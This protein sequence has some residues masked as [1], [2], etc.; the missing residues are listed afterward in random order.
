MRNG[1]WGGRRPSDRDS[2]PIM[3]ASSIDRGLENPLSV[4]KLAPNNQ[5]KLIWIK[6]DAVRRVIARCRHELA[7]NPLG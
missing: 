5:D 6:N 4:A 1:L 3:R 7:I 2:L